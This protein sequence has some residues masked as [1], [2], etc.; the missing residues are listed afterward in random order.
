MKYQKRTLRE[1][2][3]TLIDDYYDMWMHRILD[4][5]C[6]AFQQWKRGNLKHSEVTELIHKA[7]KE[8]QKV[9]SF[10]TQSRASIVNFIK[11]D[12]DWFDRWV[13]N[14]PPPPGIEL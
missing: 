8:N 13:A 6:E 2:Q 1:Y 14:H 11:V 5:L 10:F 3:Q 7:H 12:R 9:Y 4:P